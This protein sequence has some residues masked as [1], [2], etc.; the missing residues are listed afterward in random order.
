MSENRLLLILKRDNKMKITLTPINNDVGVRFHSITNGCATR[1][2]VEL[3][4]RNRFMK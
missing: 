4:P 3:K 1:S 2:S